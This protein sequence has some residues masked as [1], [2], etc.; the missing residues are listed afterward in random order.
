MNTTTT[1]EGWGRGRLL[2]ILAVVCLLALI[3]LIGLGLA[4]RQA[5]TGGTATADHPPDEATVSLGS[6]PESGQTRTELAAAPMAQVP[7]EAAIRPGT[8]ATIPAP[9]IHIPPA[10]TTGEAGVPTG[11]PHTPEGAVAQLAAIDTT[12]LPAMSIPFTHDVFAAWS[13]DGARPAEEWAMTQNV[14]VFLGSAQQ[15]GQEAGDGVQVSATPVGAQVKGTD[16]PDWV[17]ACVLLDVQA[18]IEDRAQIAYGHCEAMTWQDDRWVIAAGPA[19]APAPSTW[20]GTE[21]AAEAGWMA[22]ASDEH[23]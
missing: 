3:L 8:P 1:Q 20:P 9:T 16:G 4:V 12:V 19:A 10:T 5:L 14:A 17:I 15:M 6:Q 13:A 23:R 22:W 11:Y 21:T 18:V 2:V 7:P